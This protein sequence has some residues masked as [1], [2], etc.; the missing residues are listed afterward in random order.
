[1]LER[2]ARRLLRRLQPRLEIGACLLPLVRTK[3]QQRV[4][5]MWGT[6]GVRSGAARVSSPCPR[7]VP[8]YRRR[9]LRL[10]GGAELVAFLHRVLQPRAQLGDFAVEL[11]RG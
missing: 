2:D 1:M 10:E 3:L 7:R 4:L 5:S 8:S 9:L 6:W 11:Q